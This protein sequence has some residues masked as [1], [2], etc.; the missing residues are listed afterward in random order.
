M[1][2]TKGICKNFDGDCFLAINKTIQE[3]DKD[4]FFCEECGSQLFEIKDEKPKRRRSTVN[5]IIIILG[6]ILLVCALIAGIWWLIGSDDEETVP[7]E[8]IE[9]SSND[10]TLHEGDSIN[11]TAHLI[12][13]N[14]TDT[15]LIWSSMN[16]EV[17]TVTDGLIKAISE[18]STTITVAIPD[19]TVSTRATVNVLKVTEEEVPEPQDS[20]VNE[21][22]HTVPSPNQAPRNCSK[23]IPTPT[24]SDNLERCLNDIVDKGYTKDQRL[25]MI[26][27]II[28]K[29]F[30]SN[31]K[32]K[33][34]GT[35]DMI[36][37]YEAID[38]FLRRVALS[39]RISAITIADQDE[40]SHHSEISVYEVTN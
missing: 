13:D 16:P 27:L 20:I 31:A 7:L 9:L 1:A 30:S 24:V 21:C 4:E 3:A 33:T 34:L 12:P 23:P 11:I 25:A 32:V 18:G 8:K 17:A 38:N 28:Q 6:I 35:D 14:A 29:H 2:K 15:L 40:G 22:P 39:N 37:D 26:P 10:C 19:T 36:I 5:P